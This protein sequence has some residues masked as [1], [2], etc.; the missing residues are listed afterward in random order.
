M[1][2][3]VSHSRSVAFLIAIYLCCVHSF[4]LDP[5]N[6]R[7]SL[8]LRGGSVAAYRES[9]PN[10]RL[11]HPQSQSDIPKILTTVTYVSEKG[12]RPEDI[13]ECKV[14]G[15]WS[16]W[17]LQETLRLNVALGVWE[18]EKLLSPGEYKVCKCIYSLRRA[19]FSGGMIL[20]IVAVQ[21]KFI[22]NDQWTCSAKHECKVGSF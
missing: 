12:Q 18:T 19:F 17:E 10:P 2:L 8:R 3:S 6:I 5:R 7:C 1:V 13:K 16:N 15:S 9:L 20:I 11:Y 21:M 22:V 4:S 14:I